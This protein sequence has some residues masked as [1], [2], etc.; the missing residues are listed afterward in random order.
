MIA[1]SRLPPRPA[2]WTNL[3][4]RHLPA[5]VVLAVNLLGD[6]CA[7]ASTRAWRDECEK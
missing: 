2:P 1:S 6:G 5:L 7:T 3:L 4:S